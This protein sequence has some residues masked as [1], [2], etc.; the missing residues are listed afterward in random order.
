MSADARGRRIGSRLLLI[1]ALPLLA[2]AGCSRDQFPHYPDNYREFAYVTNS[3]S[4]SV[5]VLDLVHLRRNLGLVL[6]DNF[7]FRGTVRENIACVKRDATFAE[8]VQAA[9]LAGAD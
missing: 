9:Q 6:Q 4:N 7:L 2:L 5:T 1:F 3:G 8:V